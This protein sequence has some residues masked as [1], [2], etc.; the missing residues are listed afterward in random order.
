[1]KSLIV[2]IA[3]LL[4]G[5]GTGFALAH[6]E[7]TAK[8]ESFSVYKSR[9]DVDKAT[10][11]AAVAV[12][13]K[14]SS[15]EVPSCNVVGGTSFNFGTMN[16][17]EV[18][19]HA[20]VFQNKGKAPLHVRMLSRTCK[21]TN[22]K[23][24]SEE[25]IYIQPNEEYP[26]ELSW[27]ADDYKEVF[28]QSATVQTTDPAR[29]TVQLVIEGRVVQPFRAAPP[30]MIV[31]ALSAGA[32]SKQTLRFYSYKQESFN[33]TKLHWTNPQTESFFETEL[34]PLTQQ[35]VAQ[36]SN[37]KAGYAL[38][39]TIKPGLPIG[40][41]SQALRVETDIPN[42]KPVD[43]NVVGN[44]VGEISIFAVPGKFKFYPDFNRLAV[45]TVKRGKP[46]E[47]NLQLVVRGDAAKTC[48][49]S[50]DVSQTFPVGGIDVELGEPVLTSVSK[51]FPL[52]IR[53][54]DDQK[55]IDMTGR[56][57]GEEGR[58]V[59]KSNLEHSKEVEIRVH[60]SVTE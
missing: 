58:I 38:H 11:E 9:P 56:K 43:I 45:G 5:V 14:G 51:L 28:Q 41:I 19:S 37:A 4:L 6:R 17:G 54:R 34:V 15:A 13:E 57:P 2:V 44:V 33:I 48:E 52:K 53:V 59:I 24:L 7:R 60:Y 21:C 46:A 36:E 50:V 39:V 35:E 18:L 47:A 1:V 23:N 31:S 22:A 10:A 26:V 27:S 30:E 55:P 16:R 12:A 42:E 40:K 8:A 32:E 20:F 25:G 3:G 29:Q 49:L